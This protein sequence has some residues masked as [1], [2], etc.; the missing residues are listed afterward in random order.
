MKTG[1]PF[2]RGKSEL[3]RLFKEATTPPALWLA[4]VDRAWELELNQTQ[5][6]E[7]A[8][9]E[10]RRP[11]DSADQLDDFEMTRLLDVVCRLRRP[12]LE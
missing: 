9:A 12:A 3:V 10:F 7:L 5:L 4:I 2:D 11:V 6:L 8:A 1:G